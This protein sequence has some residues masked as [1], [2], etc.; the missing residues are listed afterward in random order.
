MLLTVQEKTPL[1]IGVF[2]CRVPLVL[3]VPQVSQDLVAHLDLRELPDLLDPRV[4]V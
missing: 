4:K 1:L 2:L 3:L